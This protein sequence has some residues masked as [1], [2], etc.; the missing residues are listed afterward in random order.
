MVGGEGSPSR[1]EIKNGFLSGVKFLK[2]HVKTP[3]R[4]LSRQTKKVAHPGLP[5]GLSLGLFSMP[6]CLKSY[7]L[8]VLRECNF[9]PMDRVFVSD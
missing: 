8:W 5:L 1:G 7:S 4:R 6:I 3:F 2:L 9:V